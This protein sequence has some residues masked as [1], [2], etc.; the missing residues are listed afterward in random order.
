[1]FSFSVDHKYD[2]QVSETMSAAVTNRY[3]LLKPGV[4]QVTY[5]GEPMYNEQLPVKAAKVKDVRNLCKYLSPVAQEFI[6]QL[7]ETDARDVDRESDYD[8]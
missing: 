8:E 3:R 5:P 7:T 2:V 4:Q 1:M 6:A